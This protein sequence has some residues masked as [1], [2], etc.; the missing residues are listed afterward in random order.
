[1]YIFVFFY[2]LCLPFPVS[3]CRKRSVARAI[4]ALCNDALCIQP[5]LL[6]LLGRWLQVHRHNASRRHSALDSCK[7]SAASSSRRRGITSVVLHESDICLRKIH[8]LKRN[9]QKFIL[10]SYKFSLFFQS[11]RLTLHNFR[12][13][14]LFPVCIFLLTRTF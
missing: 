13:L 4:C 11:R 9:R 12:Q 3:T 2:S 14:S 5:R 7:K 8:E 6:T 1:M 10:R